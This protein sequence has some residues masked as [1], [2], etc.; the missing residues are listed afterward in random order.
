MCKAERPV[1]PDPLR[2]CPPGVPEK[3]F[4]VVSIGLAVGAAVLFGMAVMFLC[5]R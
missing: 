2:V 4:L 5:K 3:N 1:T